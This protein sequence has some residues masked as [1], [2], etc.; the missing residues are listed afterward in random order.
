MPAQDPWFSVVTPAHGTAGQ[1]SGKRCSYNGGCAYANGLPFEVF[2]VP[3]QVPWFSV[4]TPAHGTAGQCSGN[5][6]VIMGVVLTL[7]DYPSWLR[8][9]TR[10]YNGLEPQKVVYL[11]DECMG[12]ELTVD[13]SRRV[14]AL[15]RNSQRKSNKMQ[16]CIKILFI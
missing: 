1:C 16:E 9:M 4:V 11:M 13:R 3:A 10:S 14:Q 6:A 15:S 5:V 8:A 12:R 2:E 7:T